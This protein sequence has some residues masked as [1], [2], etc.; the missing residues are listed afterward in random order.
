MYRVQAWNAMGGKLDDP[1]PPVDL[2]QALMRAIEYKR[3]GMRRITLI[4]TKTGE[5]L[6]DLEHLISDAPPT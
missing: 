2:K 4:D 6:T 3:R 5:S 1:G